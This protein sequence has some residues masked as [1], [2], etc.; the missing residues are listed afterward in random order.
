MRMVKTGCYNLGNQARWRR[1]VPE[2]LLL[3]LETA[4]SVAGSLQ[5]ID[6][7]VRVVVREA[8][9]AVQGLKGS[10]RAFEDIWR[11][12]IVDVA[13][14]Q[15]AKMQAARPHLLGIFETRLA[16]LKDT[17]TLTTWLARREKADVPAPDILLSEIAGMERLKANVFDRWQTADDLEDLAA[18][19]YPLTTTD[20]DR[21]GP[22]RRPP[23]S[24][25]AEESKPF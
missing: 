15:T 8:G 23:A 5:N 3:E 1:K 4:P 14:G 6:D 12:I 25:Y 16:L 2:N 21:I 19:D 7:L 9:L 11:H 20:L 24:Y 10:A 18:R 17:H 22:H 13:K